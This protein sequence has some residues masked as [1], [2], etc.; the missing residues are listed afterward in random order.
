M[1]CPVQKSDA[2]I[3]SLRSIVVAA[4]SLRNPGTTTNLFRRSGRQ[5]TS[6]HHHGDTL[7]KLK[8][9]VDVMLGQWI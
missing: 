9:D 6:V 3:N 7:G 8:D 5:H 4:V 2:A 1:I